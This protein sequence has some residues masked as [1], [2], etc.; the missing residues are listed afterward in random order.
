[1]AS[2]TKRV[3]VALVDEYQLISDPQRG[4]AW[5]RVLLGIPAQEIHLTGD[6]S[7][8]DLIRSLA[9]MV[10]D[11]LVIKKYQRLSPLKVESNPLR[12]LNDIQPGTFL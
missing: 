11:E 9:A 12:S 6:E 2:T 4:W 10:G 5:T 7:R 1:M 3:D 8:V